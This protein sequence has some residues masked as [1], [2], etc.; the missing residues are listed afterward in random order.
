MKDVENPTTILGSDQKQRTAW[1]AGIVTALGLAFFAFAVYSVFIVQEGQFDASDKVTMPVAGLMFLIGLAGYMLAQRGQVTLS[2]WVVLG[3]SLAPPIAASLVLAGIAPVSIAFIVVISL[4]LTNLVI[5]RES[6][7]VAVIISAISVLVIIGIEIWNPDFRIVSTILPNFTIAIIS[8]IVVT[9]LAFLMRW[10]WKGNIRRQMVISFL[11][12]ALVPLTITVIVVSLISFSAQS[13]LALDSQD[14]IAKRVAEQVK[15]FVLAREAELHSLVEVDELGTVD[16][17]RQIKLLN[18]LLSAQALYNELILTNKNGREIIYVSRLDV[19]GASQLVNRAGKDEF[20]RPKTTGTTYFSPVSF[21]DVSGE[22]YQVI[23]IPIF[24]L[25]SGQ[26]DYVLIANLRFKAIWDLMAQAD[27][28]G[29]GSVYLVD[30]TNQVVAH[31]NPSIALQ[32]KLVSLPLENSFTTGLNGEEVAMALEEIIFN[33]QK[34]VV[35]AEQPNEEA[36]ALSIS[37]TISSSF[38][39]LGMLLIAGFVGV[40]IANLIANPIGKLSEAAQAIS[41][42][43]FSQRVVMERQDEIGK[44]ASAFNSMTSQLSELIGSLEQRVK[45]RTQALSTVAEISAAA[46]TVLETDKLLQMVVDLSK[47]SFGL[48][49]SHIYLLNEAGDTLVLASGAGKPG[50]KMVAEGRSIPLDR[51]QSLVARAA[52]EQKGV[53]VNDVT[54]SPDFLPNPLLPNTRSELAVPMIVGEQVI[55]VFDVQS[56]IVERFTDADIA[57]QTTLASQVASAI[58]NARSYTELQRSQALLSDALKAARLGNWEFD[59]EK[60]LFTFSDEFYAIF[61]TTAE[62][63]GGYRISSADYAKNFVHPEDAALVG[64][65]I[66]K[67]LDAKDRLFT[68]HL[69]HRIIF[70]DGEVGYIAV[71]INVERD[72]NGKITRWYGANQDITERKR[73][74]EMT[75]Q[76]A[77]QQEAVNLI[78]QQIQSTTTV[79][80]ALQVAARELGRAVGMKPTLVTLDPSLLKIEQKMADGE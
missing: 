12:V 33:E 1:A 7:R 67:V 57:V 38:I 59:F 61:R 55:G 39:A 48:Y 26:L 58:Q 74:E 44:L 5:P 29:S 31:A 51:E 32:R 76:R 34:F 9:F 80:A 78:T 72:E 4:L 64:S 75:V 41:Q 45:E 18:N 11:L 60:D 46:S 37:N 69:E 13:S 3:V 27:V 54:L 65:E 40:W 77:R 14:Q 52:R 15:N 8:L 10:A 70:S 30:S 63:V 22:P 43:D 66:Q 79:D 50:Q 56:D 35:V 17:E 49:H 73:L 53:T 21:N 24:N 20:E 62:K 23:S 6:R 42:G 19:I 68:T 2:N 25:R 16:R 71:N 28:I 47:E 36:L